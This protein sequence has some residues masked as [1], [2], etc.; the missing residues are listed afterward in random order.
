MSTD[1]LEI[2]LK[3]QNK[4]SGELKKVRKD[5][6]KLKSQ[7]DSVN[8]STKNNATTLKAFSGELD[9]AKKSASG[10]KSALFALGGIALFVGAIRS[11]AEFEASMSRVKA[12]LRG[13]TEDEF[14]A[15]NEEARRLGATTVF[16]ASQ[17]ANGLEFLARAGFSANEALAALEGTLNLAAAGGLDLGEAA[18]IASNVLSGFALSADKANKVADILALT[19]A[20]AN[21]N[22]SQLGT[23]MAYVAPIAAAMG[24]PIE[25][26]AAAI[27][28]LSDAGLQGSVAGTGLR[29]V[30]ST[31]NTPSAKLTKTLK[32]LGLEFKDVKANGDNLAE[33]MGL[34]KS[35]GLTAA[36]ALQLFGDRG[37]PA[38]LAMG[39]VAAEMRVLN[40]ELANAEGAAKDMAKTMSDNILGAFKQFQSAL[41]ETILQTGDAGLGGAIR[42]LL[43]TLSGMI[44]VLNGTQNPLDDNA[45][46]YLEAANAAKALGFAIE[47]IIGTKIAGFLTSMISP[48]VGL[49]RAFFA[50]EKG[51]FKF[52][53]SLKAVGKAAL[54][55]LGPVGWIAAIG[56]ALYDF[57]SNDVPN[58]LEGLRDMQREFDALSKSIKGATEQKFR[59]EYGV[60]LEKLGDLELKLKDLKRLKNEALR[61]GAPTDGF[62]ESIRVIE[63]QIEEQRKVTEVYE[64]E[65]NRREE[66]TKNELEKRIKERTRL[67][68][69]ADQEE[70]KSAKAYTTL[71]KQREVQRLEFEKKVAKNRAEL[72]KEELKR[73]LSSQEISVEEY[74]FRLNLIAQEASKKDL[75]V[76]DAKTAK[77]KA[78]Y[79]EEVQLAKD[80]A[81]QQQDAAGG[82]EFKKEA[83]QRALDAKLQTL[84]YQNEVELNQLRLNKEAIRIALEVEDAKLENQE[85]ADIQKRAEKTRQ[86]AQEEFQKEYEQI[87]QQKE[88]LAAIAQE[89]NEGSQLTYFLNVELQGIN[90]ETEAKLQA[91]KAKVDAFNATV[92]DPNNKIAVDGLAQALVDAN[93]KLSPF[94]KLVKEQLP[95]AASGLTD[96]FEQI[97]EGTKSAQEAF[98]DFARQFLAQI[99]RMIAQALILK[100]LQAAFGFS[101]GGAVGGKA[102]Q[103][104]YFASTGGYIYPKPPLV[105]GY[106]EGGFI[107]GK[108]TSTSDSIPARLS[109]GEYVIQAAAVKQYGLPFIEAI[110]RMVLPKFSDRLPKLPIT[111][112]R[113]AFFASGGE[114]TPSATVAGKN[115]VLE[116]KQRIVNV[117][118][119]DLVE[120]Y[121][122]SRPGE[123][124]LI[125]LISRNADT[126]KGVLG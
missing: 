60:E 84:R 33:V 27:G 59:V 85:V 67:S 89:N 22:V 94:E 24:V 71:I 43:D 99:A 65:A 46:S 80:A 62:A 77:I 25:T 66:I 15:L 90:E 108:G 109:T 126:I 28:K 1:T 55:A 113:R 52:S 75:E 73:Q 97:G 34:L 30:L 88:R 45:Q 69:E 68:T 39:N 35:R 38:A 47:I 7:V 70:L 26:A 124:L 82:D 87:I 98:R 61:S 54:T 76:L 42:D 48:L 36:D 95:G 104:G 3:T 18:D 17:A 74:Y 23:A 6:Q 57:Y 119:K 116:N 121:L 117:V 14:K 81:K 107:T 5:F 20:S 64:A 32:K 72:Q 11:I 40:N 53:F 56:L 93:E 96:A 122:D 44:R 120:S 51:A 115:V 83:I 106:A 123:E 118:D 19:A 49:G 31:L 12:V 9:K 105:P 114:V 111:R 78:T 102:A 8:Q 110:N 63:A 91:L 100:S 103:G 79:A 21:T 29:R 13:I 101:G 41:E 10:L 112:P 2:I 92:Q 125:N 4:I 50:A 37:A 16:S 58:T 86:K